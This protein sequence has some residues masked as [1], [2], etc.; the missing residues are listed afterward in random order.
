MAWQQWR[1]NFIGH[2]KRERRVWAN[3]AQHAIK[4]VAELVFGPRAWWYRNSVVV[5]SGLRNAVV[6]TG[7]VYRTQRQRVTPGNDLVAENVRVEVQPYS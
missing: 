7:T 5:D 2:H 3:D 4:Q 6:E 1:V